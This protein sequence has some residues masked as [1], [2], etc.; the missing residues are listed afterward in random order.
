M[1]RSWTGEVKAVGR[2]RRDGPRLI[3]ETVELADDAL[4][5]FGDPI[6]TFDWMLRAHAL[7]QVVPLPLSAGGAKLLQAT[8]LAVF[9]VFGHVAACAALGWSPT[10]PGLPLRSI[11]DVMTAVRIEQPAR[12]AALIADGVPVNANGPVAGLT[13]LHVAVVK[14]SLPLTQR[15]LD[16]GA[17]PN[18]LADGD[19]SALITA[20]VHR[21]PIAILD[22]LAHHGAIATTPNADGFGMIHAIAETDRVEYLAWALAHGLDLEAKNKHG[23]TALHVAAGLGHVAAIRALLAAGADRQAQGTD[24]LTARQIALAEQKPLAVEALDAPG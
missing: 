24:G 15:L 12:I 22:A 21:A 18:V 13:A 23:H 14:G 17:D 1:L 10:D 7:S 16:L 5:M 19:A 6:E 11:N 8:P 9:S 4:R 2:T 3:V 20:I